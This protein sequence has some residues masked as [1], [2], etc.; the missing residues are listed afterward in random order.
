VS[1]K[2]KLSL[3]LDQTLIAQYLTQADVLAAERLH[4]FDE[5]DSTNRFLLNWPDIDTLNGRVCLAEHQTAGRGRRGKEWRD[6]PGGSVMLSIAWT[7]DS[8]DSLGGLSLCVGVAIVRALQNAGIENVQLKWPNDILCNERKLGGIL[9]ETTKKNS[10]ALRVVVGMGLNV[11]LNEDH[12]TAIDQPWIGLAEIQQQN[13]IE[14]CDRNRLAANIIVQLDK[15]FAQFSSH[16]FV[17][18][19]DEW[20]K[21][22]AYQSRPVEIKNDNQSYHGIAIG[23]DEVGALQVRIDDGE[24]KTVNSG[25]VSVR[26]V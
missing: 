16:G 5:I 12:A 26:L 8:I 23:V 20:S 21:Y 22:H 14:W 1:L 18:F 7:V 13:V 3:A 6:S 19:R 17:L 9:V 15:M 4:I 2:S 11:R 25:E 24:L 10:E